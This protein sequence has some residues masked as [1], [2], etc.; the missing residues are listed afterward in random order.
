MILSEKS[1]T[2][3]DHTLV[4]NTA[5]DGVSVLFGEVSL[6]F[7]AGPFVAVDNHPIAVRAGVL[8][9]DAHIDFIV[10]DNCANNVSVLLGDVAQ[11]IYSLANIWIFV[12][13]ARCPSVNVS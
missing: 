9:G 12:A 4:A 2:F 3:R 13:G 1:A 11:L 10:S 8:D 5:S 6:P 7:A